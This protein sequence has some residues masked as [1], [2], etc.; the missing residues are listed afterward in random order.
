MVEKKYEIDKSNQKYYIL[1]RKASMV[2]GSIHRRDIPHRFVAQRM[3]S[4]ESQFIPRVTWPDINLA[5]ALGNINILRAS[6]IAT[7]LPVQHVLVRELSDNFI[8]DHVARTTR[9]EVVLEGVRL[10]GLVAEAVESVLGWT[11]VK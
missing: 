4:L 1:Q 10:V 9:V 2:I 5:Q 6:R 8:R 11:L 3:E 7:K